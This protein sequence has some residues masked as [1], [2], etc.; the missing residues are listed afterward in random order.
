MFR[1]ILT[2]VAAVAAG[3]A[4][5]VAPT[6]NADDTDTRRLVVVIESVARPGDV[7]DQSNWSDAPVI[8]YPRHDEANQRWEVRADNTI[9]EQRDG[10][11]ATAEHDR[12][13]GG[14]CDTPAHEQEWTGDSMGDGSWLIRNLSTGTCVTHNGTKQQL[15]LRECEFDRYDQRWIIHQV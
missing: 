15:L 10:L 12:V 2:A 6:A 1:G 9:Q 13:G 11:C 5:L 7:W 14:L 4:L 3:S 8:A